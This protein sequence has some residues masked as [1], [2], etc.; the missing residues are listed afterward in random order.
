LHWNAFV[1]QDNYKEKAP[2]SAEKKGTP[3]SDET[4]MYGHLP[5]KKHFIQ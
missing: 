1:K 4:A 2:L 3:S 5:R